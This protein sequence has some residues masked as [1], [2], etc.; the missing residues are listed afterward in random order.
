[1]K[2]KLTLSGLF[3]TT[4]FG[5]IAEASA[6]NRRDRRPIYRQ[7]DSDRDGVRYNDRCV[8]SDLRDTL[9]IHRVDTGIPNRFDLPLRPGPGIALVNRYGCSVADLVTQFTTWTVATYQRNFRHSYEEHVRSRQRYFRPS[10]VS[11]EKREE[12]L[13]AIIEFGPDSTDTDGDG[14]LDRHDQCPDSWLGTGVTVALDPDGPYHTKIPN[15]ITSS[16]GAEILVTADGCSLTDII[17][18]GLDAI[19]DDDPDDDELYD[20]VFDFLFG[21]TDE[22]LLTGPE[23]LNLFMGL[24]FQ[25]GA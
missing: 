10:G 24:G 25:I 17:Q 22:G 4:F 7:A 11:R 19:L 5:L 6:Q 23:A 8:H 2:T 1:M 9:I 3:L 16:S 12:I 20:E 18:G 21:L 14:V 13:K 15:V